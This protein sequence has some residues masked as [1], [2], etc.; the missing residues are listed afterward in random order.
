MNALP[1]YHYTNT[2]GYNGI[3]AQPIWRFLARKPPGKRPVG[4]YFTYLSPDTPKLAK[5]LGIPRSKLAYMFVFADAGDL[6]SLDGGRGDWIL[7]SPVD[8]EV[9]EDRQ[10][11]CGPTGLE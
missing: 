3:R 8:Y 1:L 4:A 5:R 7:Y 6:Q 10:I 2:A 11:L 9:T